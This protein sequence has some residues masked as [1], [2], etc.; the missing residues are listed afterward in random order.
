[1]GSDTLVQP[2][3]LDFHSPMSDGDGLQIMYD[4]ETGDTIICFNSIEY[5]DGKEPAGKKKYIE[6]LKVEVTEN[7]L[8][9]PFCGCVEV[10]IARTN[11]NACW[12]ECHS[13]GAR[14]DSDPS[15]Y[16]AI[17]NWNNRFPAQPAKIVYDMD[18]KADERK[19]K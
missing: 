17:T 13:C 14:G 18:K 1:M 12:V 16:G 6:P 19:R 3:T 5:L 8:S 2:W 9:C 7:I 10:D 4:G 11:V 15:R